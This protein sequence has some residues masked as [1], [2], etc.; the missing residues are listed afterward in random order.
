MKS[1]P[2][3]DGAFSLLVMAQGKMIAI[4]DPYGFRPLGLAR[5]GNAFAVQLRKV[6]LSIW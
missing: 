2:K 3:I 4:R 5:L 1:L 6:A